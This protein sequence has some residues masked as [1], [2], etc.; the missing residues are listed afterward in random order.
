MTIKEKQYL[1]EQIAHNK[2][3]IKQVE[4]GTLW[5]DIYKTDKQKECFTQGLFYVNDV[6]D[7]FIN[8]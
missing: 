7:K 2:N 6:L 3:I 4:N 1:K 5:N 8:E